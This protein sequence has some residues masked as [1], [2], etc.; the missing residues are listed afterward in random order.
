M[1]CVTNSKT[2]GTAWLRKKEYENKKKSRK[3]PAHYFREIIPQMEFHFP[4][5]PFKFLNTKKNKYPL[6][7]IY[8]NIR[9]IFS[10]SN[11]LRALVCGFNM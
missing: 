8:I 11:S 6:L 10:R 3:K 9:I 7:H 4:Y 1:K 2:S 5:K